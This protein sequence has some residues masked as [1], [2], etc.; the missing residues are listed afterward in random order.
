MLEKG[1][2]ASCSVR[3][4]TFV[5]EAINSVDTGALVVAPEQEKVFWVLDL[6]GEEEADGLEGL[7][8]SVYVV[9]QEQ[10]VGLGREAAILKKPQQVIVLPMYVTCRE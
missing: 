5:I 8:A 4:L 7:F 10:V 3:M 2:I 9:T 6:V 1:Y